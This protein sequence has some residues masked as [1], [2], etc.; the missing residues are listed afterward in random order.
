M[1]LSGSSAPPCVASGREGGAVNDQGN[2][3]S[4]PLLH[5]AAERGR[6]PGASPCPRALLIQREEFFR[7][8]KNVHAPAA[9]RMLALPYLLAVVALGPREPPLPTSPPLRGGEGP[10]PRARNRVRGRCLIQHAKN[11]LDWPKHVQTPSG[12]HGALAL[13][14]L[15][16]AVALGP[17]VELVEGG[18]DEG[19][20]DLPGGHKFRHLSGGH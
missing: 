20:T 11:S 14:Y 13:P 4:Q 8:A 15:L 19:V 12:A 16:A 9:R 7:L 3:L 10:K 2:L 6:N 18:D 17:E 5:F 1:G